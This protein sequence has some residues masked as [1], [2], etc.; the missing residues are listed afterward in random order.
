MSRRTAKT[1][2][3]MHS[4]RSVLIRLR[5]TILFLLAMLIAN[6]LA[7]SLWHDLPGEVLANWGIGHDTVFSGEVFRV[8]TGIFL[9][10]DAD[11]LA[12]QLAF[13]AAVIGYAEWT[14]GTGTT[15]LLFFGLDFA[16]SLMLLACVG[17]AEG[18]VDLTAMND[19]GMSIGGFGLIG[20]A[21]ADFQ[22]K[23]LLFFAI[24]LAIAVKY[25]LGPDALADGG[26]VLALLL[27][28]GVNRILPSRAP[29][30]L[31]GGRHAR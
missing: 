23:W 3:A 8:F 17:W 16:G 4:G 2:S 24:L 18:W 14:Y 11:M 27:G 15:A 26:H 5:F 1:S 13:A 29:I 25:G 7:G 28:F 21:I 20:V 30:R 31:R 6:L 19:V 9:S 22:R 10:H 12:R